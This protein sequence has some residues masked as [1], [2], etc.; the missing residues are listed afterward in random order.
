MR[1]PQILLTCIRKYRATVKRSGAF[2][3]KNGSRDFNAELFEPIS[4]NLVNVWELVFRHSFPQSLEFFAHQWEITVD[5]FH[6]KTLDGVPFKVQ[7]QYGLV[8]L[9]EQVQNRIACLETAW[10]SLKEEVVDEAGRT[11]NRMF[12]PA[13]QKVMEDTYVYCSEQ[14]GELFDILQPLHTEIQ[15]G[16]M[17]LK[18]SCMVW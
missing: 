4:K 6:H 5:R 2:T 17:W 10:G 3:G 13:I 8:T 16:E 7:S 11:A 1:W 12:A 14:T 9:G 15:L 18:W